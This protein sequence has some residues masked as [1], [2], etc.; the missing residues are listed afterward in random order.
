MENLDSLKIASNLLKS[1]REKLK[2]SIAE[3]SL[4]LRLEKKIIKNIESGNFESFNS[5]LFLKGYLKNYADFLGVTVNLPE[6]KK[7]KK[8][9]IKNL[10]NKNYDKNFYKYMS[11]FL[12]FFTI[13]IFILLISNFRNNSDHNVAIE[14]KNTKNSEPIN[15][16]VFKI[17]NNLKIANEELQADNIVTPYGEHEKL[18]TNQI[19][20]NIKI[21]D[22]SKKD[23]E[24][25]NLEINQKK[26]LV[27]EYSGDS[28]TEIINSENN[29]VFFDLVKNGK[30]LELNILA[31]FEILLCNAT[32]VNI[33]YNNKIV[34]V[35]YFNPDNNVGK[36]KIDN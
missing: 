10:V 19:D 27:I 3:V 29:I 21:I 11:G 26:T 2:L 20:S 35:P 23:I 12:V 28:W 34:N 9:K 36:I 14:I 4:E 13:S 31:P 33:K 24:K 32:V 15:N 6:N 30:T 8:Y 18:N 1:Q 16:D 22:E 5:Y 25:N 17:E 7:Q